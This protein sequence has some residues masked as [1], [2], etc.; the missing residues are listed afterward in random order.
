MTEQE[1]SALVELLNRITHLSQ[2]ERL[3]ILALVERLTVC[4]PQDTKE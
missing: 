4:A 1:A 2:S 3:W